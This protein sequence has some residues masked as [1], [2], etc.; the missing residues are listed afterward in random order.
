[1]EKTTL[2]DEVKTK[3]HN[4]VK[5]LHVGRFRIVIALVFV[6]LTCAIIVTA[7]VFNSLSN[8][9]S[10]SDEADAPMSKNVLN[11]TVMEIQNSKIGDE[12][13]IRL[14]DES[15]KKTNDNYQKTVILVTKANLYYDNQ[16]YDRA[17]EIAM[18]AYN[19]ESNDNVC[20]FIALIYEAK[21]DKQKAIEYYHY[22]IDTLKKADPKDGDIGYY[23]DMIKLLNGQ[24]IDYEE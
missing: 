12:N 6:I 17:L 11:S 16:D 22:A 13:A 14:A 21:G 4:F 10:T 23:E 20:G 8:K 1:M 5:L 18:Q 15:I 24:A 9:P 7:L 3:K 2:K 19:I